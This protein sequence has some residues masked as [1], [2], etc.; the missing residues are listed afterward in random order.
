MWILLIAGV[1]LLDQL[2]KILVWSLMQV[3]ESVDIIP[4]VFRF[5]YVQNEGAAFGMLAE[6]RWI[7][8]VL[9]VIGIA[10]MLIYLWRFRPNSR[11]ACTA[12]SLIIGGGIGNMIDRVALGYVVD[13]LDFC[14][15]PNLWMWVFNVADSCVCI[16]A[17]LLI[18]WLVLDMVREVRKE[19][20]RKT[21]EQA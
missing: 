5:T 19:K 1:V 17:G 7:F 10:A 3:G 14:A 12:L 21:E 9:S 13:F 2:T 6:H 20:K 8:M 4:N 15:F 11:L 18:L 16:G